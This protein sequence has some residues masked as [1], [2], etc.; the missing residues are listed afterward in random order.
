MHV[1]LKNC[2]DGDKV[3]L[4]D[5]TIATLF[6]NIFDD[7][8]KYQFYHDNNKWHGF[9]TVSI[10]GKSCLNMDSKDIV[11]I[12]KTP[13]KTSKPLKYGGIRKDDA[14]SLWNIVCDHDADYSFNNG[15]NTEKTEKAIEKFRIRLAKIVEKYSNK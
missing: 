2:K 11:K 14:A 13:G 9:H 3:Q 10:N 6:K 5:G 4:R 8:N 7:K 12:I 1:N 15:F